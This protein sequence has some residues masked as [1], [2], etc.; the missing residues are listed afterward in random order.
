MCP[1]P[2]TFFPKVSGSFFVKK[3][4]LC[5]VEGFSE[6]VAVVI[7]ASHIECEISFSV[8]KTGRVGTLQKLKISNDGGK[9]WVSGVTLDAAVEWGGGTL[10]PVT[11]RTIIYPTEVVIGGIIP[12]NRYSDPTM[13]KQYITDIS[14]AYNMAAQAVNDAGLFPGNIQ[15]RVEILPVDPG[16]SGTPTTVTEVA[17]AF[18]SKR[19]KN[20]S[21]AL[22]F[23][24]PCWSSNAIPAARAVS[25]PFKLPMV[26]YDSWTSAL[27]NAIEF[28]YFIRVG[29]ANSAI[30]KVCGTFLRSM[31]WMNIAVVT[32]DDPFTSDY[33]KG[34]VSDM[35]EHGATVLY[36]GVFP[37]LPT[38]A[39]VDK[40][41][42]LHTDAVK[43]I[44][45]HMFSARAK[46]ARVIVVVAKGDATT[47]AMYTSLDDAGFLG[48]GY[49]VFDG[50]MMSLTNNF[51]ASG[52]QQVNGIVHM[53]AHE[54]HKCE[55]TKCPHTACGPTCVVGAREMNQAHDAVLVLATAVAPLFRD[56]GGSYLAG[57]P[58]SR[59]AA[60]AALFATTLSSNI[61]AS[62]LL[63]FDEY[64][65]TTRDKWNFG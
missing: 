48:T 32:D 14:F 39:A 33:G 1:C 26:S 16:G 46:G 24:G 9:R 23:A 10:I 55:A 12:T 64:P 31:G 40:Q 27:D 34:V 53:T 7:D 36:H 8:A 3:Y 6:S 17:T 5:R 25:N 21:Y 43:N 11:P 15:L 52:Q 50:Q 29:P 59:K 62:G 47:I 28:P 4:T 61:A 63:H 22:G 54:P 57:A 56:G 13:A 49:A 30:S 38:Q 19:L 58:E 18:A 65:S 35:K 44:S 51:I 41:G 20:E 2:L 45:S 60:M 37:T 42:R